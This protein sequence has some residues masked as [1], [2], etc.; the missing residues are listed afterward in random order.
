MAVFVESSKE[1]FQFAGDVK[2]PFGRVCAYGLVGVFT[3]TA[4]VGCA[5]IRQLEAQFE[6][7][8]ASHST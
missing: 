1:F 5:G 2:N 7:G 4:V 3:V 8:Q 6:P